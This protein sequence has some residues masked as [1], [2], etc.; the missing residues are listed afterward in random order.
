MIACTYVFQREFDENFEALW[1]TNFNF[2]GEGH[3][4]EWKDPKNMVKNRVWNGYAGEDIVAKSKTSYYTTT[5][6]E[7]WVSSDDW[8]EAL[9]MD[10]LCDG[11]AG[12][13]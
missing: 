1:I 5:D 3:K 4:I 9:R 10:A 6:I 2:V 13:S 8:Y 12:E 7:E 11:Y